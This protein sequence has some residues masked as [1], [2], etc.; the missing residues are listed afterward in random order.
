MGWLITIED[1]YDLWV[2]YI[3][4]QVIQALVEN[5]A[6]RFIVVEQGTYPLSAFARELRMS[7]GPTRSNLKY[8]VAYFTIWWEQTASELQKQQTRM[9]VKNGQLEF[10]IGGWTMEDEAW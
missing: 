7:R 4:D 10:I 9:L 8:C 5:P 3:Y 1:Y 6:R 2:R